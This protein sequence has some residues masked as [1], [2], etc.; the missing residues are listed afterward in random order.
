MSAY[1]DTVVTHWTIVVFTHCFRNEFPRTPFHQQITTK[2]NFE[3]KFA[4]PK[5]IPVASSPS[6]HSLFLFFSRFTSIA[7]CQWNYDV[8]IRFKP[9]LRLFLLFSLT[10]VTFLVLNWLV[11]IFRCNL[12]FSEPFFVGFESTVCLLGS[13]FIRQLLD[14]FY[15]F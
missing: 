7:A 9:V 12:H 10:F 2:P 8:S 15:H 5:W 1:C 4:N 14:L 13:A 11:C 3:M 6:S